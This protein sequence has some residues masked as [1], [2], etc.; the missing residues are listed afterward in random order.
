MGA[1]SGGEAQLEPMPL[2]RRV[3]G[4]GH[5]LVHGRHRT[6]R[7]VSLAIRS[8]LCNH[9][10]MAQLSESTSIFTVHASIFASPDASTAC[11]R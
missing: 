6:A 3:L 4:D 2:Q 11:S 7:G 5:G 8:S 1:N 10:L 9:P